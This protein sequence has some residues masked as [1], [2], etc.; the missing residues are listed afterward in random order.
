MQLV[1]LVRRSLRDEDGVD[2]GIQEMALVSQEYFL[3]FR[4]ESSV[5]I[6]RQL[7]CGL[8]DDGLLE[9]LVLIVDD[10]DF[11]FDLLT[12]TLKWLGAN[13]KKFDASPRY[14]VVRRI[15]IDLTAG[16]ARI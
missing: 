13:L 8:L 4:A 15:V 1:L 10:V 9:G 11:V 5:F 2:S 14:F 7:G 12:C 3:F 16:L 6:G